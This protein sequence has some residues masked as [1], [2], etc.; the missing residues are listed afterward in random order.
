MNLSLFDKLRGG[1]PPP[2]VAFLPDALFFTRAVPI[3]PG[4]APAEAAAQIELALEGI[5]PFPLAQLY[6]GWFWA[7]GAERAFVFAAYRRR[8]TIEQTAG[9]EGAELVLPAFAALLGGRLGP[10]TTLMLAS[11][12]GITA[13]H[14][15]AGPVPAKVL[16]RP[17]ATEATDDERA[18]ARA[19]LLRAVGGSKTVVDLLAPPT[20]DPAHSQREIVFRA[21]NFVSTLSAATAAALDVRDKDELAALRRARRRDVL[22]WRVAVGCAAALVLLLGGEV[23]RVG[24]E[25][26]Q[27]VRLA[28][29]GAQR[30][31]VEAIMTSDALAQRIE[32]LCTKRML[33]MEMLTQLSGEHREGMP[34]DLVF[35][36]I[37]ANAASGLYTLRVE[38]QTS[39]S[40][41]MSVYKT[42]LEKLPSCEKIDLQPLGTQGDIARFVLT[43]S[44]K[45]EAL[46]PLPAS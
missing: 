44:F 8:F 38:A 4:A 16:F 36:R 41:Q 19:E 32:E 6:Y 28:K 9:W 18:Q 31:R 7:P 40:G 46:A 42:V 34:A 35:T 45:P 20:P 3:A 1:P 2:K 23:A 15:D 24:G 37:T 5:S 11:P 26:W 22:L 30:P 29:L 43:I 39:N 13:V 10:A 21:G 25:Q 14:W 12:E 27:K 33:P 17:V